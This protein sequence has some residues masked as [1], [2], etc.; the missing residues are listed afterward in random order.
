MEEN[1]MSLKCDNSHLSHDLILTIFSPLSHLHITTT[2]PHPHLLL[3]QYPIITTTTNAPSHQP[4]ACKSI[5][6]CYLHVNSHSQIFTS[7]H[8]EEPCNQRQDDSPSIIARHPRVTRCYST[9]HWKLVM[10]LQVSQNTVTTL[11][12]LTFE[13]CFHNINQREWEGDG[14]GGHG[15][16]C[17]CVQVCECGGSVCP[18]P[19]TH[20]DRTFWLFSTRASRWVTFSG[21]TNW[22]NWNR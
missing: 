17:V 1:W 5:S 15:E 20:R 16:R 9:T 7:V 6:Q 22:L 21:Q 4:R 14:G 19:Q 11:K 18:G 10:E 12:H 3:L 8:G 13:S 2:C